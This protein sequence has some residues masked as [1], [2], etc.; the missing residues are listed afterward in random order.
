MTMQHSLALHDL[1]T[2]SAVRDPQQTAVVEPGEGSISYG[3]L[4]S[5]S[6]RV[7]DRLHALGVRPGD[8]VGIYMRKSIDAVAAICG[9]L[10]TGAAYVPVDPGAP[11]QRNA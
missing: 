8:R 3:E 4:A 6:D 2:K 11:A 10:K 7:R 1:F 5:L 9:I